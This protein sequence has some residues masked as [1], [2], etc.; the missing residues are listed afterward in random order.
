MTEASY[1]IAILGGGPS[2]LTL[3]HH[4]QRRGIDFRIFVE[5]DRA[6]GNVRSESRH[7]YLCEWG[8]NGFLDNEPAMLRLIDDLGLQDQLVAAN[9]MAAKR[10]VVRNGKP[11]L[12]PMHPLRFLFGDMLSLPGRLRAGLEWT[13]PQRTSPEDET[14]F[15]FAR[16]RVG[17]EAAEV[18]VD[19][20]VT[21]V[22]A[23]DSH[24]LS[25]RSTFPRMEEL[26]R[27]YGGLFRA[28]R[29]IRR[30]KHQR[31]KLGLDSNDQ[32]GV[33][34]WHKRRSGGGGLGPSGLLHSFLGGMQT[35]TD[36]LAQNLD[37]R[38]QLGSMLRGLQRSETG[39]Q[40]HFD[41]GP[42]AAR[43]V[44]FACPA[45]SAAPLLHDLDADLALELAGIASAPVAVVCLGFTEADVD[46]VERGFG[47]LIPGRE[48]SAVLGTL[49]DTW[50]FPNRSPVGKVLFRT[51]LGGARHPGILQESD[52]DLLQ[53]SRDA[54]Q[55]VVGLTASPEMTYVIRHR[56]G[57]AQYN[58]GHAA[59]LARI[60]QALARHPGLWLSGSSY[61]GVA[62]NA[63]V[64]EAE[65]LAPRLQE[66]LGMGD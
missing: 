41:S 13:R 49:Y 38:L 31:R 7:D 51:L 23:G 28:M 1:Q 11:R 35:L 19:A 55:R 4:L 5:Q 66:V 15:D 9:P 62:L 22:Y 20:M 39:W 61:H 56:R 17:R 32:D 65:E 14:V 3:G 12:L 52:D 40:L 42:V 50:V 45:W 21:G 53:R 29:A 58:L 47:F 46:S 8:P 36:T 33:P 18:L 44:V 54:L 16:R 60:D 37:D 59:R 30:E 26:E 27:R 64:R 57:I 48:E 63:C 34:A 10:W 24:K 6:G 2:G 25:L 43:Q